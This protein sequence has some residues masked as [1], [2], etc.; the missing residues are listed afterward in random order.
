LGL[1]A[2]NFSYLCLGSVRLDVGWR[3]RPRRRPLLI[4][5]A[6]RVIETKIVLCVL[7]EILGGNSVAAHC[8]FAC[9]GNVALEYLVGA[10]ADPNVGAVAV[11]CLIVLRASRLLFKRAVCVEATAGPLI[12]S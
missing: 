7:V 12:W 2:I 3:D 1:E 6:A 5:S 8:R 10:A 11:E 9:Q 4:A